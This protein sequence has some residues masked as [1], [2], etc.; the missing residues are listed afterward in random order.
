MNSTES[1]EFTI[2]TEQERALMCWGHWRWVQGEGRESL[3]LEESCP[4]FRSWERIP[5]T[6][7]GYRSVLSGEVTQSL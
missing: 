1:W 2:V 3:G 6:L 5:K 4:R 7:E